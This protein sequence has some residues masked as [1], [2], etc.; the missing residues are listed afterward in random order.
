M[1]ILK[2]IKYPE[3]ILKEMCE[4]VEK[5]SKEL[6]KLLDDMAE[7]MYAAPGLGL[8][9]PQVGVLKRVIVVDVSSKEEGQKRELFQIIN[10]KISKKEG[11]IEYEEG[12][13][14]IPNFY[15]IMKRAE[16]IVIEGLDKKGKQISIE[17]EGLLAICLQHE[18]DHLDG[19]LIIDKA[20]PLK[21]K[22]YLD[23]VKKKK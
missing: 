12:C 18:I 20:S 6:E 8:A 15:Q 1:S 13:L 22:I 16:K 14:S 7:T 9:A 2:I 21:R 19:K 3:P 4:P 10:P 5:I 23:Q 11:A 17:A